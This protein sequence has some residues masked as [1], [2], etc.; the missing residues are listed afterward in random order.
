MND[1]AQEPTSS[2]ASCCGPAPQAAADMRKTMMGEM[3]AGQCPCA[4]MM[5]RHP[6][7]AL[8]IFT[9]IGLMFLISQ[10]GGVLGIIAFFRTL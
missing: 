3:A 8:A 2:P 1:A 5:K 6:L 7:A 9:L 4:T 10:V